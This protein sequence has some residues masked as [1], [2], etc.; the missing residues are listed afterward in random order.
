MNV[1]ENEVELKKH[2]CPTCGGQLQVNLDKQMY[3]C[4]FCGVSFDY[5]YFREDDVLARAERFRQSG[6]WSA[7][8]MDYDF[9]LTKEPHNFCALRG[10]VLSAAHVRK[11]FDLSGKKFSGNQYVLTNIKHAL[12]ATDEEHREYFEKLEEYFKGVE[13]YNEKKIQLDQLREEYEA[14]RRQLEGVENPTPSLKEIMQLG[15]VKIYAVLVAFE[16]F[17]AIA[18]I[19]QPSD[20][21]YLITISLV[22]FT[23]ALVGMTAYIRISKTLKKRRIVSDENQALHKLKALQDEITSRRKSEKA[24]LNKNNKLR[25]EINEME[26]RLM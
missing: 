7:A 18:Y 2:T 14:S 16:V 22:L 1:S 12:S 3:D 4:P 19:E 6:D 9:I 20:E 5:S 25:L 24:M 21:G 11:G 17:L 15:I 13:K 26:K 10:K 8:D 23:I